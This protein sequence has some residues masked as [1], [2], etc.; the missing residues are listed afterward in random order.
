MSRDSPL[1]TSKPIRL[2]CSPNH[3]T[4]RE[5]AA[6]ASSSS[7][8][9]VMTLESSE[10]DG[11]PYYN[12]IE[13][14][15]SEHNTD[16]KLNVLCNDTRLHIYLFEEN[17]TDS[18]QLKEKYFFYLQVAEEFELDGVTVEDFYDW[19]TEPF[20]PLLRSI[21]PPDQ[22]KTP[23]L[24]DFFYPKILTYTL[25]GVASGERF[26]SLYEVYGQDKLSME[27]GI[28]LLN[29]LSAPWPRFRPSEI[30]ICARSPSAALSGTPRKV[31]L[32]GG[33]EVFFLK[34]LYVGD[35][36]RAALE[37]GNYKRIVD[38]GLE[39]EGLRISHL[40][41]LLQD[42]SGFLLGFLH[43]YI[44]CRALNLMC[45]VKP[46]LQDDL[47]RRWAGQVMSTVHRLHTA[48]TLWGNA[49][50]E[51]VLVDIYD[52]AWVADFGGGYT[53]EWV[54]KEMAGTVEGDLQ[55]LANIL[56]HLGVSKEFAAAI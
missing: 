29:E 50:A 47:R 49:K 40:L 46:G 24:Q 10:I 3:D 54:D 6:P 4:T 21:L 30:E 44:G 22:Y 41:G 34:L 2:D 32:A 56:E 26:P 13:L 20:L 14:I 1:L 23:T 27:L 11:L 25:K 9:S 16:A 28:R 7:S 38:L 19:I 48:G 5:Q 42:D 33:S 45:A 39:K 18:P 51:N 12:V 53:E 52:N 15:F 35:Q 43:P 31:K 17:F 36:H 55:G 37:F 8:S